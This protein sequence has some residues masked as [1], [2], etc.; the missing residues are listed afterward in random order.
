MGI[1]TSRVLSLR[2]PVLLSPLKQ[3]GTV[4]AC[5][6]LLLVSV[7]AD[8]RPPE[9]QPPTNARD[10]LRE[11]LQAEAKSEVRNRISIAKTAFESKVTSIGRALYDSGVEEGD[12]TR[13]VQEIFDTTGKKNPMLDYQDDLKTVVEAAIAEVIGTDDHG[14]LQEYIK[15]DVYKRL[16]HALGAEGMK[17]VTPLFNRGNLEEVKE[18]TYAIVSA[19]FEKELE[20]GLAARSQAERDQRWKDLFNEEFNRNARKWMLE[21]LQRNWGFGDKDRLDYDDRREVEDSVGRRAEQLP[22]QDDLASFFRIRLAE[23]LEAASNSG[24]SDEDTKEQLSDLLA[25]AEEAIENPDILAQLKKALTPK[26]TDQP[27]PPPKPIPPVPIPPEPIPIPPEPVPS[28]V[29]TPEKAY[30]CKFLIELRMKS[31]DENIAIIAIH[32]A[33]QDSPSDVAARDIMP[34][35]EIPVAGFTQKDISAA[36]FVIQNILEGE[37][38]VNLCVDRAQGRALAETGATQTPAV[39]LNCYLQMDTRWFANI[40]S[41][42]VRAGVENTAKNDWTRVTISFAGTL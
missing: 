25:M 5:L 14:A 10:I 2:W 36:A 21:T 37:N 1:S 41:D 28:P 39:V 18:E 17:Q 26:N 20:N 16:F 8:G 38:G 33:D 3:T 40:W 15:Q 34:P 4:C 6:L 9:W 24:I 42:A 35:K 11:K 23:I 30:Q 27:S 32:L 19:R 29:P 12:I 31:Q 7:G 13:W 22:R